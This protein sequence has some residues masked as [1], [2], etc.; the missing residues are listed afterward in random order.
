MHV[1]N[2]QILYQGHLI[3]SYTGGRNSSTLNIKFFSTANA[4][5]VQAVLRNIAFNTK[6]RTDPAP[7]RTLDFKLTNVGGQNSPTVS[8]VVNVTRVV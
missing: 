1:G 8:R 3:A 2:T 7:S 4:E 6:S 5:A